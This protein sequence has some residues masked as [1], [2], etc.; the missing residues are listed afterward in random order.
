MSSREFVK[1]R[2]M[3]NKGLFLYYFILAIILIMWGNPDSL[4]PLP[5]R[6]AFLILVVTPL[7]TVAQDYFLV[8]F[9]F[10]V[11]LSGSNHAVSYM[12]ATG[13]YLV[14]CTLI[15]AVFF[16][17][18][19]IKGLGTS[20]SVLLLLALTIL[21]DI[22]AG[23]NVENFS[24]SLLLSIIVA[25]S[26]ISSER[27][28]QVEQMA[29]SFIILS[30]VLSLEYFIWG[31]QFSQTISVG[32]EDFERL[33]WSDPNY[34][35]CVLGF[36]TLISYSELLDNRIIEK[37]R[38]WLLLITLL[39]SLFVIVSTASRGAS[40]ALVIA[41]ALATINSKIPIGRKVGIML[42]GGILLYV[43]YKGGLF[44]LLFS[45]VAN[46]D[47]TAGNRTLIWATKLSAFFSSDSLSVLFGYGIQG[48][49]W[50]GFSKAQGFHNDYL[51]FLVSYGIVGFLLFVSVILS[52]LWKKVNRRII[53]PYLAYILIILG[54][55]EPISSGNIIYFYFFLFILV[56]KSAPIR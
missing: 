53:F 41:I 46:D 29:Y 47:G 48:G 12:P 44:D 38:N 54:S 23:G 42:L 7:F 16:R 56:Q 26:F 30:L 19:N 31:G 24:Y 45:R 33:G 43:T 51:A 11:I 40:V 28:W 17:P 14:A 2:M 10:F 8:I 21:V 49:R 34:F 27:Q 25:N 20:F 9:F 52:P 6:I 36:G 4:P 35:S 37:K 15:G 55:L 18:S 13:P 50:L 3:K 1:G 32:N 39:L 22:A 5:L